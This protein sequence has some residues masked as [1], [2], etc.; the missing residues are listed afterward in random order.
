MQEQGEALRDLAALAE[1]ARGNLDQMTEEQR[2]EVYRIL[3]VRVQMTGAIV[4]G[5]ERVAQPEG[6]AISGIPDP[7][8]WDEEGQDG[9]SARGNGYG[10]LVPCRA[11][12]LRQA[13]LWREHQLMGPITTAPFD[14][15]W[16]TWTGGLVSSAIAA[17]YLNSAIRLSSIRT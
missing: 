7:R 6:L 17:L 10:A 3:R 12:R 9:G 2:R 4:S 14:D 8:M 13:T 1:L 16:I 5:T 15:G 11:S